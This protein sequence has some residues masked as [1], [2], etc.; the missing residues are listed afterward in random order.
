MSFKIAVW[1]ATAI[2]ALQYT[3]H[4]VLFLSMKPQ[5][6][7]E[8][9][10]VISAMQAHRFNF[11]GFERSYW[12]FYYGYGVI[13]ILLGAVEIGIL[14]QVVKLAA[15]DTSAG[16]RIILVL[17]FLN[18]GHALIAWN[19]FF[20]APLAFDLAVAACLGWALLAYRRYKSS[21]R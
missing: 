8:E 1:V 5:H 10:Q 12:D 2:A 15:V 16:A 21:E 17:L 3:V 14:W 4:T 9:V 13:A 11:G 20:L 18:L 7:E 19:Y 6:G